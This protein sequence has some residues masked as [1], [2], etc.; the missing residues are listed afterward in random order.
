MLASC[1]AVEAATWISSAASDSSSLAYLAC[2]LSKAT[3]AA[4]MAGSS[5][6][7]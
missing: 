4:M 7:K 1:W 2:K 3:S 5:E 6:I